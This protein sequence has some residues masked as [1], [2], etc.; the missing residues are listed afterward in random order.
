VCALCFS[1]N[2]DVVRGIGEAQN[3]ISFFRR[4][5]TAVLMFDCHG[6]PHVRL[7]DLVL[8][9]VLMFDCLVPDLVLPAVL[10]FDCHGQPQHAGGMEL[11]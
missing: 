6:Q 1:I 9:A 2:K 10:M 3:P 7:P 11:P 8:P 5:A 4:D